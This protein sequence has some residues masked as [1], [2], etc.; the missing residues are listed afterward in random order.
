MNAVDVIEQ[1]VTRLPRQSTSFTKNL[2]IS[3]VTTVGL[4]AT[5]TTTVAHG[6]SVGSVANVIKVPV[7]VEIDSVTDNGDNTIS[8]VTSTDNDLTKNQKENITVNARITGA[9]FDETYEVIRVDNRQNFL[10]IKGSAQ[11]IPSSG[12]FL[13]QQFISGYNGL[14]QA[15]SVPTTTSFTYALESTLADAND[16]TESS[17]SLGHR[18]SG[19]VTFDIAEDSYTTQSEQS[20]LWLYVVMEDSNPNKDRRGTNDAAASRGNK[21]NF[22]QEVIEEFTLFLFVPNKGE[23]KQAVGGLI[24]RDAALAE[25]QAI[26]QSILGIQ[27]NPG[28]EWPGQLKTTYNGDGFV[29]YKGAYYIHGFR[30]QQVVN[31]TNPDT[32]IETDSRAF[33]DINF[34][35]ESLGIQEDTDTLTGDVDLDDIPL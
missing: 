31:I 24:A 27:Y 26:L 5:A 2:S 20:N 7:P 21:Q 13:Q 32:A 22:Q 6:L 29:A 14:K 12:F 11:P 25:R 28:F 8:I 16:L 9:S 30:F 3:S 34:T 10:V 35:I 33:R 17:I 18:I 15:V 1:L 4:V 23:T 19:A